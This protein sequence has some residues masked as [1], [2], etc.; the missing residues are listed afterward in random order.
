MGINKMD[1]LQTTQ[2]VTFTSIATILIPFG[3]GMFGT[4]I[5]IGLT[6]V[7]LGIGCLVAREYFKAVE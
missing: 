3:V 7:I 6:M 1:S 5:W 4:N 2:R